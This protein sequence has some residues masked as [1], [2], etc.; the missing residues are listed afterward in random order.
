LSNCNFSVD[1]AIQLLKYCT[2]TREGIFEPGYFEKNNEF[3]R[4]RIDADIMQ[5]H[6]IKETLNTFIDSTL[7]DSFRLLPKQLYE[8]K[9]MVTS[10][11]D[12]QQ[13][14]P[15]KLEEDLEEHIET[16]LEIL[17]AEGKRNVIDSVE[18]I[19]FKQ[20]PVYA[21]DHFEYR[22]IS[23]LSH[24]QF[25]AVRN[26]IFI[27]L[28]DSQFPLAKASSTNEIS[29]D[30]GTYKIPLVEILPDTERFKNAEIITQ[31]KSSLTEA[32]FSGKKIDQLFDMDIQSNDQNYQQIFDELD[33]KN[34]PLENSSQLAFV[35]LQR[36]FSLFFLPIEFLL[37]PLKE[38]LFLF[39]EDT[40]GQNH[41]IYYQE[42]DL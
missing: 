6:S 20:R 38:R 28:E 35:L 17:D 42:T 34:R 24:N 3:I 21:D 5:Y 11:H 15:E 22:L 25:S 31:I 14:I 16:L 40:S 7:S 8:F 37:L 32:G 36:H 9:D 23:A 13:L 2:D 39:L 19:N 26:K 33:L 29:F 1:E 27:T 41:W 4:Y 18:S 12:V 30:D 10:T